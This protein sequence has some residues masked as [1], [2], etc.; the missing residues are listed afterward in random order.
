MARLDHLKREVDLAALFLRY[1]FQPYLQGFDYSLDST[2]SSIPYCMPLA[3]DVDIHL[4]QRLF[5]FSFRMVELLL[6]MSSCLYSTFFFDYSSSLHLVLRPC[7]FQYL[8]RVNTAI[9]RY[10]DAAFPSLRPHFSYS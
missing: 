1:A 9:P 8:H 3:P 5:S 10:A 4:G 6:K 7:S 2:W